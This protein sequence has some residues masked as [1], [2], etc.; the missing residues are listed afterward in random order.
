MS[1]ESCHLY[2]DNENDNDDD[3]YYDAYSDYYDV[4][5]LTQFAQFTEV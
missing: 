2:M 1:S 5:N 3:G 4:L